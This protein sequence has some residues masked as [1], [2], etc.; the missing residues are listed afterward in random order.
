M[1]A[2]APSETGYAV[3][4][5]AS[6]QHGAEHVWLSRLRMRGGRIVGTIDT[7]PRIVRSLRQGQELPV[8]EDAIVDWMYFRN[9][10]IVGNETGR[11]ML[12]ALPREEA[13]KLLKL[14]E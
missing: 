2:N 1:R 9:G 13:E 5:V 11:A 8:N 6:D 14:Y 12:R 4:I 3:K 7:K 10:L